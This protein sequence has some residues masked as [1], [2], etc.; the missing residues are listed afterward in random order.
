MSVVIPSFLN[1]YDS[2][3][4]ATS[5]LL[6]LSLPSSSSVYQAGWLSF[7]WTCFVIFPLA[8][9]Q[10]HLVYPVPGP[11]SGI[12]QVLNECQLDGWKTNE[13]AHK[14]RV[15]LLEVTE[16][17]DMEASSISQ[18]HFPQ[19]P[20][21][22]SGM[23][24]FVHTLTSVLTLVLFMFLCHLGIKTLSSFVFIFPIALHNIHFTGLLT[25]SAK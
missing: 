1:F 5:P 23:S 2:S 7:L 20:D 12:Q 18:L 14:A 11:V 17:V 25:E 22:S 19:T 9:A 16:Q 4:L 21:P 8:L 24:V 3:F 6:F 10:V 15:L 13:W